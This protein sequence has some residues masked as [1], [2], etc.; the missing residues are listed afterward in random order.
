MHAREINHK[1]NNAAAKRK[2]GGE[3][4]KTDSLHETSPLAFVSF[5]GERYSRENVL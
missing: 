2:K 3:V 1:A 5:G 4:F